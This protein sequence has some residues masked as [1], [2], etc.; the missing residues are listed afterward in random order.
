MQC[1]SRWLCYLHSTGYHHT[2]RFVLFNF[3]F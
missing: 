2:D 3:H 1:V